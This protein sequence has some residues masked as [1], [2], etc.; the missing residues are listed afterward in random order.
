MGVSIGYDF[1][2]TS[3]STVR[4][5]GTGT[6]NHTVTKCNLANQIV[7]YKATTSLVTTKLQTCCYNINATIVLLQLC[8][9]NVIPCFSP[10]PRLLATTTIHEPQSTPCYNGGT[11]GITIDT[12]AARNIAKIDP[13]NMLRLVSVRLGCQTVARTG[14]WSC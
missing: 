5:Y 3:A 11:S 13:V 8:Y 10:C 4:F 14:H 6:T 2:V 12:R 7:C 9:Y 1:W